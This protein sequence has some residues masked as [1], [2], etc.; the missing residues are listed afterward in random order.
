MNEESGKE[1]S[2]NREQQRELFSD[3]NQ[4]D[5]LNEYDFFLP[6]Q[7]PS[8]EP[9]RKPSSSGGKETGDNQKSELLDFLLSK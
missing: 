8:A 3:Q 9:L 5:A 6:E 4:N 7:D 2:P 1:K